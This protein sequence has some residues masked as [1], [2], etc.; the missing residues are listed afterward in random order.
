MIAQVN[1]YHASFRKKYLLLSRKRMLIIAGISLMIIPAL[2]VYDQQQRREIAAYSTTL[3]HQYETMEKNWKKIQGTLRTKV[4][5]QQLVSEARKL[6]TIFDNRIELLQLVKDSVFA[7][8]NGQA[9]YSDY[10]IAL[11]RQYSPDLWLTHIDVA[12]NGADL[13]IEGK[14]RNAAS[15][16]KYLQRLTREPTLAGT[17]LE[18]FKINHGDDKASASEPLHFIMATRRNRK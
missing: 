6:K 13:K 9:S 8:H 10:L 2:L 5:D 3:V 4:T 1:L 14:T 11:A 16:T 12:K 18:I 15:V 7:P 17:Q